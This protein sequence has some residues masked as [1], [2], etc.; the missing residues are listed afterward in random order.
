MPEREALALFEGLPWRER[1]FVRARLAS[2]PLAE[3][4]GR[5]PP[6]TVADI[7]C[8]HGLLTALLAE[9]HPERTVIGIDPDERKVALARCGP[10]R[11]PNVRVEQGLIEDLS[12]SH[13]GALDAIVIAD[14]LYL[15]P[16]NAWGGFLSAARALLRPGGTL[17]LKEAVAD[18]SWKHHKALWQEAVM[19]KLVGKTLGSGGLQ[20]RPPAF[21]EALLRERGF[22]VTQALDLSSGYSSP[23]FLFVARAG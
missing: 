7:G 15:L 4:A 13:A 20:F 9:G 10:G 6:G 5:A 14:V 12:G 11:L 21:T 22:E 1:L 18:G 2:A 19:V 23:H 17:L 3:V 16:V 8:G